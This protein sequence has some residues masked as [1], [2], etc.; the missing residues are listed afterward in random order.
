MFFVLWVLL[1]IY[2]DGGDGHSV[3]LGGFQAVKSSNKGVTV[4]KGES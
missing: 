2:A 1:L 4:L 3:N